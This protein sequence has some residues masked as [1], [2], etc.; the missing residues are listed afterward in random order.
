VDFAPSSNKETGSKHFATIVGTS[1]YVWDLEKPEAPVRTDKVAHNANLALQWHSDPS[2]QYFAVAGADKGVTVLDPRKSGKPIAWRVR[3]A[4][5][6]AIRDVAWHPYIP[7][8]L[9]TCGEDYAVNIYDVRFD[10]RPV[11]SMQGQHGGA[12][13]SLAWSNSHCDFL[14]TGCEDRQFR[15]WQLRP[16][17][18]ERGGREVNGE[19]LVESIPLFNSSV[20]KV[21]CSDSELD[22]YYTLSSLGELR[23]YGLRDDLLSMVA[24]HRYNE[25]SNALEHSIESAVYRRDLDT[26]YKL[27][28]KWQRQVGDTPERQPEAQTFNDLLTP[29]P[30]FDPTSWRFPQSSK[31]GGAL[32]GV[33]PAEAFP[34]E[35]AKRAWFLPPGFDPVQFGKLVCACVVGSMCIGSA[36]KGDHQPQEPTARAR[37][38]RQMEADCLHGTGD[39]DLPRQRTRC[40][41]CQAHSRISLPDCGDIT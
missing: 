29:R 36:R 34:R 25:S 39:H 20:V 18:N 31:K 2:Y 8:W 26:A 14:A 17:K 21:L 9:T 15:V 37:A 16:A 11:F 40:C 3:H 5:Y 41:G 32:A 12:V 33:D 23:S 35:M 30:A 10:A 7:Y 22:V 19:P 27:V 24:M 38:A 4:H 1:Y 13:Y 6:Q 28:Q